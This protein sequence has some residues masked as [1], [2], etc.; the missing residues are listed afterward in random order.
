MDY[1]TLLNYIHTLTQRKEKLNTRLIVF[2]FFL[3]VASI[4]WYLNKLTYEYTTEITFPLRIENM[5]AGKVLVGEPPKEITLQVR[6]FG[7]TLLRYKLGASLI[8]MVIDLE[9]APLMPVVGSKTKVFLLTST[10]RA[11]IV[12]QLASELQLGSIAT[13]SLYFEFTSL[14]QKKVKVVPILNYT[15]ERQRMLSGPIVVKPDSIIISGPG[16]LIDTIQEVATKSVKLDRI[17]S[18]YSGMVALMELNQIGFSHR[19][20]NLTI[21]VERFT[22]ANFSKAIEVRNLPDTLRLIL[23]PRTVNIKCNVLLSSYKGLPESGVVEPYVDFNELQPGV[24][25]R[26]RIYTTS[27]PYVVRVI[28]LEPKYADYIIERI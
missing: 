15:I 11:V 26:L 3:A 4:L 27:R 1:R 19:R 2:T 9:Q 17:S 20:V 8:P 23:L 6:S 13:D 18:I 22:E 21:P 28:D 14:V 24:T 12:N 7:Y 25:N 16:S 5:P 10:Q